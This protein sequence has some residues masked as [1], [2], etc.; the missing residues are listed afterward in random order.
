M[1]FDGDFESANVDQVRQRNNTTFDVW[2]RNDSNGVGSL[3]WFYFRMKNTSEFIETVRI[4]VVNFTKGNSLFH[5]GMK[6][7]VWSTKSNRNL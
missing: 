5:S 6:P 7:S 1:S 2:M 4:N 3:Q